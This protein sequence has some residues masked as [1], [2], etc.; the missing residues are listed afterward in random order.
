MVPM[1]FLDE[2]RNT[3]FLFTLSDLGQIL[4]KSKRIL[5]MGAIFGIILG[6]IFS[7]LRPI[8][9][10]IEGTFREKSKSQAGIPGSLAQI[11][12]SGIGTQSDS[13]AIALMKS[14]KL[15]EPVIQRMGLQTIILKPDFNRNTYWERIYDNLQAHY[16]HQSSVLKP[17]LPDSK[18]SLF[19][20]H[21]HY[22]GEFPYGFKIV[23]LS[24]DRYQFYDSKRQLR[25]EGKVG[26]PFQFDEISLVV[27]HQIPEEKIQSVAFEGV[28]LPISITY[29]GIEGALKIETDRNDS[30][31]IKLRFMHRD[32]HLGTNF[33]NEVM[34][35]YVDYLEKNHEKEAN[36]QLAYLRK[37]QDDSRSQLMKT[38]ETH[39]KKLSKDLTQQGFADS[40]NEMKF[41]ASCQQKYKEKLLANELEMKRLLNFQQ[42]KFAYY[43]QLNLDGEV[44]VINRFLDEIRTLKQQ[45]DSLELVLQAQN[46]DRQEN[47]EDILGKQLEDLEKI[48]KYKIQIID[49]KGQ[50]NIDTLSDFPKELINDADY[51]LRAWLDKLI[52][53]KNDSQENLSPEKY[54]SF[55]KTCLAYLDN[56]GRIFQLQENV[57]QQRL[58]HQQNPQLEF[59]GINL[60]TS[61]ELF[62][63]YCRNLQNQEAEIRK[64]EFMLGQIDEPHFEITSL[65]SV[66]YDDV[67]KGIIGRAIEIGL[68]TKDQNN[69]TT[70]ELERLKEELTVQKTFL[71]SHLEQSNAV[72]RINMNLIQEKIQALREVM[73]ELIHQQISLLEKSLSDYIASQ[74]ESLQQERHIFNNHLKELQKQMARLPERWVAEQILEK[75]INTHQYIVQEVAKMVESKNISH[76]LEII[77]SSPVDV[78]RSPMH[79]KSPFLLFYMIFGGIVGTTL[80]AVCVIGNSFIKGIPAT[81]QNL[82]LN[83][84]NVAGTLLP[85]CRNTENIYADECLTFFRKLATEITSIPTYGGKGNSVLFVTGNRDFCFESL[86]ELL[87]KQGKKVLIMPLSFDKL[88]GDVE[89]GLLNYLEKKKNPPKIQKEEKYGFDFISTGGFS[90]FNIELLQTTLF[91]EWLEK[92]RSDYEIILMP[93]HASFLSAETES[94]LSIAQM[95]VACIAEEKIED[96]LHFIQSSQVSQEKF[97]FYLI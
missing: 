62:L 34:K 41:L 5:V 45:Q 76:H 4:S 43:D 57:I 44:K 85:K 23:F 84:L 91:K 77:Q 96:I 1:P 8:R 78:A 72:L 20:S 13:E 16:A 59:Q 51:L 27:N 14:K 86:A 82:R 70:R 18:N 60:Q 97:V 87:C 35:E 22:L 48:K 63:G 40:E 42:G 83:H 56:L 49:L 19:I 46:K 81:E 90:R 15:L 29:E 73:F 21:V 95:I 79:P 50:I 88:E 32:R 3:P 28:F 64:N 37:K 6:T 30:K 65:S 67:S 92:L 75:E 36:L 24:P 89:Q 61:Q 53:L 9:Y 47:R 33:V 66:L 17:Y 74:L 2:N 69:R 80:S 26:H 31:L 52:S 58:T 68:N 12:I 94:L 11:L 10:S 93:L 25:G 55:K 38:M 54:G 71:K 39:A 7:L